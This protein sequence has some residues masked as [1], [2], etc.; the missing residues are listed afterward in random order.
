[1][2]FN[3]VLLLFCFWEITSKGLFEEGL[4]K[5]VQKEVALVVVH[6]AVALFLPPFFQ[7]PPVT[8]VGALASVLAVL[9][10]MPS[11]QLLMAMMM[12]MMMMMIV[13]MSL[14]KQQQGQGQG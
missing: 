8:L 9:L 7:V 3:V 5:G 6:L 13:A 10:P 11:M 1:M 4:M 14:L 2:N 12:M